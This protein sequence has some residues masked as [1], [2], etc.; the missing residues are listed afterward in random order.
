MKWLRISIILFLIS[1]SGEDM[2]YINILH[3]NLSPITT[4]TEEE[5][6]NYYV[7]YNNGDDEANGTTYETAWKTIEHALASTTEGDV[8][9]VYS[10]S[11]GD[12]SEA[13][14]TD[15]TDWVEF[16][17]QTGETPVLSSLTLGG[18]VSQSTY[19]YLKF[20]GFTINGHVSI[21]YTYD[22]QLKNSTV[23]ASDYT[24]NTSAVE[25][26][27]SVSILVQ[28]CEVKNGWR[29][30]SAVGE[31]WIV[32]GCHVHHIAEDIV[33]AEG[34]YQTITGNELHDASST[35]GVGT[36]HCSCYHNEGYGISDLVIERN[37]CYDSEDQGINLY[38]KGDMTGVVLRHNVVYN[39][40]WISMLVGGCVDAIVNNNTIINK[41]Y[42]GLRFEVSE[43]DN[44]ANSIAE[45]YNNIVSSLLVDTNTEEH[46]IVI[47]ANGNN[48]FGNDPTGQGGE[49]N[50]QPV[51]SLV[52]QD[53]SSGFFVDY[54]NDDY[55][56]CTGSE[57]I[58]FGHSDYISGTDVDGETQERSAYAGGFAYQSEWTLV[59]HTWCYPFDISD[60]YRDLVKT[61][62]KAVVVG[63]SHGHQFN[64]YGMDEIESED[65]NFSYAYD[66]EF[67]ISSS[68][69]LNMV[70]AFDGE[71]RSHV[72]PHQYWCGASEMNVDWY[73]ETYEEYIIA[74]HLDDNTDI[75][76]CM[77]VWCQQVRGSTSD[78]IEGY[79]Y[80]MEQMETNYPD[81]TFLYM[82]GHAQFRA[83]D[84][85]CPYTDE[86]GFRMYKNSEL[87]RDF[88]FAN[89]KILVDTAD[90]DIYCPYDGGVD[91]ANDW[92]KEDDRTL[93]SG[94]WNGDD[95]S[96]STWPVVHL[97][98]W[99][100]YNGTYAH[101]T[102][103][104]C[105]LKS[106]ALWKIF[107]VLQG[108]S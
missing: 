12:V 40:T 49:T 82:T 11:Y 41:G 81:V 5:E 62:T 42:Y 55:H 17:A 58:L 30:I 1:C 93:S 20:D 103:L 108:W 95:Y 19:S 3:P 35:Y 67:P 22:F 51:D 102:L 72:Y 38:G 18:N 57:A 78:Y 74:G 15:R 6:G 71:G 70:I 36:E 63:Q 26:K 16:R 80:A 37:I 65:S 8:V 54:D 4:A 101:T 96:G 75:N 9:I 89:D 52:S 50:F 106:Q 56:L 28:N 27:E 69:D 68:N 84:E 105:Q 97:A 104:H 53:L 90:M 45:F 66:D 94:T 100:G 46:T 98:G 39:T 10:G 34:S 47:T 44:W 43:T 107:A 85:D 31:Y 23:D 7:D 76:V 73:L 33:H 79:L 29:G 60:T 99:G 88:C 87:V 77:H 24:E 2:S 92:V 61:N 83:D 48:I 91:L 59:D 21:K 25:G 64:H 32:D 14:N 86:D 13:A